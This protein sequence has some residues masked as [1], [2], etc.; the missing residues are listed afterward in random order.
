M[1]FQNVIQ[2]IQSLTLVKHS[3]FETFQS[4]LNVKTKVS[5]HLILKYTK[6]NFEGKLSM[7][8]R[9]KLFSEIANL[10]LAAERLAKKC[11]IRVPRPETKA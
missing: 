9:E 3:P 8:V 1:E 4:F 6:L 5:Y 7:N 2:K 11:E 10:K